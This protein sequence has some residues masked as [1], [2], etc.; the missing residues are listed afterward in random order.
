MAVVQTDVLPAAEPH[1][2]TAVH[3]GI[4]D[5]IHLVV[6]LI[7]GQLV[8]QLEAFLPC[9]VAEYAPLLAN[10]PQ[11]AFGIGVEPVHVHHGVYLLLAVE[12]LVDGKLLA[13]EAVDT[14]VRQ[15]PHIA[16]AVLL[17]GKDTPVAQTVL[18]PDVVVGLCDVVS[19]AQKNDEYC[20]QPFHTVSFSVCRHI[21]WQ[22][23]TQR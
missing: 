15:K 16:R 6:G 19:C 5:G 10:L 12:E 22:S 23:A 20:K 3:K 9:I 11:C 14:V 17:D 21:R 7:R 4:A 13:V 18:H 8:H 2:A 1:R